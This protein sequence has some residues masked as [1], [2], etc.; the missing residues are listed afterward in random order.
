[1]PASTRSGNP[2]KRAAAKKPAD[3]QPLQVSSAADWNSDTHEVLQLPS[4]K[5][6]KIE[7]IPL[8]ALLAENLLGDSL[9]VLASQAVEHGQGM[10]TSAIKEMGK[11]PEKIKEA[12]DA[13]DRV[14]ARCVVEPKVVFYKDKPA[15]P[16]EVDPNVVYSDRIDINDKI[17]IFQV[18]SGGS[19]DLQRFRVELP[20]SVAGVSAS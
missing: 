18:I 5:V 11:D 12:F 2:A 17:F 19:T 8:T 14:T 4:G 7:R 15:N 10:D 9:S 13:F 3:R 20:E 16:A 1:M 6:V